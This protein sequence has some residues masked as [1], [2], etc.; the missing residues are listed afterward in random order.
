SFF[1]RQLDDRARQLVA[2]TRLLS[3]D[4]ALKTAAATADHATTA[5][6][7]ENHRRR[8]DADI[9]MLV[10]LDGN[11][12][13]GTHRLARLGPP[14]PAPGLM[15]E[16]DAGGAV[17]DVVAIDGRFSRLAVVPLLAPEPIAWLGAGFAIDDRTA[18]DLRLLSGLHV[19]FVVRDGGRSN[20]W[21]STLA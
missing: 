11:V 2:A 17:S 5:S 13:A 1:A 18:A 3:G 6:M 9:L 16:A 7:L 15:S 10:A 4:F 8:V 20:V 14:F 21:A 12:L 19:S